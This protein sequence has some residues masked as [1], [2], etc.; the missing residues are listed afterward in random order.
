[1]QVLRQTSKGVFVP[2][3]VGGGIREFTDAEGHYYSAL[4]V[5]AEY[6]RSGADK[7]S[8]GSDAVEAAEELRRTGKKS[9]RSAIEQISWVRPDVSPSACV[10][11][12]PPPPPPP[13][14]PTFPPSLAQVALSSGGI[15]RQFLLLSFISLRT[16]RN[17]CRTPEA[18]SRCSCRCNARSSSALDACPFQAF[19]SCPPMLL[20]DGL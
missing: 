6:F 2:L 17:L 20:A 8:I 19:H 15:H 10:V 14:A 18:I 11:F 12:R 7:V 13:P 9:G 5:A 4:Q 3:T 1:M 16:E